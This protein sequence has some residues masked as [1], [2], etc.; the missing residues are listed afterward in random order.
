[1]RKYKAGYEL[2][3]EYIFGDSNV[4]PDD[5]QELSEDLDE[6]FGSMRRC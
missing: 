3:A 5:R 4:C 2:L 1:M 6:I